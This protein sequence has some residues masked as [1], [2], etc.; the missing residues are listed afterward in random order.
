MKHKSE[1]S[2]ICTQILFTLWLS[3]FIPAPDF[4][5]IVIKYFTV[6]HAIYDV[7]WERQTFLL[8]H[9]RWGTFSEEKRLRFEGY[10]WRDI[11]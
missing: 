3:I 7:T 5:Y 9:R 6:F 11:A 2:E 4:K 1:K 10:L 8:A